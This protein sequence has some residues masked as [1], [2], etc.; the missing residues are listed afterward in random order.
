MITLNSILIEVA[1]SSIMNTMSC[2]CNCQVAQNG[3]VVSAAVEYP[4]G[5]VFEGQRNFTLG[6]S[7]SLLT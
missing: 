4:H 3:A 5:L 1:A 7:D 6:N 2:R